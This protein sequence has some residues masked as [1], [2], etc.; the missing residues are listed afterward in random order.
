[1]AGALAYQPFLFPKCQ[2][3]F[4][5]TSIVILLAS[6]FRLA[7]LVLLL[8]KLLIRHEISLPPF[9]GLD[10]TTHA[11]HGPTIVLRLPQNV[12][13]PEVIR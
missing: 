2:V 6:F 7:D 5:V 4:G 12:E 3:L 11:L 10:I 9:F 13:L 1:M 8:S